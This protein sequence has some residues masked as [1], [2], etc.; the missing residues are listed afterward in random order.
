M[1]RIQSIS[2]NDDMHLKQMHSLFLLD[3]IFFKCHQLIWLIELLKSFI[4]SLF[5]MHFYRQHRVCF[6][7]LIQSE[8]LCHLIRVFGP[9][10]FNAVID[11]I[12]FKPILLVSVFYFS[13]LG[14][15]HFSLFMTPIL[16]LISEHYK[17]Q[18]HNSLLPQSK[19]HI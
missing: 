6:A 18:G 12:G 9:F 3:R 5:K 1:P 19:T 7:F 11:M 2:V 15:T 13:H 4:S 10:L 17:G 14:F 16:Q 8:N